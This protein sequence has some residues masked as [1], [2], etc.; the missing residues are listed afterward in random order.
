V[1]S[2]PWCLPAA[3]AVPLLTINFF[4]LGGSVLLGVGPADPFS[5]TPQGP[6][7]A[8]CGGPGQLIALVPSLDYS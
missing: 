1:V 5:A 2:L 3:P 7:Y 8:P 6:G 4:H